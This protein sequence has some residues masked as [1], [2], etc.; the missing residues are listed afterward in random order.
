MLD[1][2]RAW[3]EES[4]AQ[5][6]IE[7]CELNVL[8]LEERPSEWNDFDLATTASMLEYIPREA[9]PDALRGLIGLLKPGGRL[10]L[11]IT[12]RD[13][14]TRW[15]VGTWWRSNLYT[16]SEISEI[17]RKAGAKD[18]VFHSMPGLFRLL[19]SSV[20]IAEYRK[21]EN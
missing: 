5:D 14:M 10:V 12:R 2:F 19:M 16:R 20:I 13:I 11:C 3:I 6:E 21:A 17:F 1:L 8:K 9:M 15:L 4:Q 7:L 18:I